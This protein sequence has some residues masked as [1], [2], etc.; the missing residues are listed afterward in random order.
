L[1]APLDATPIALRVPATIKGLIRNFGESHTASSSVL[2]LFRRKKEKPVHVKL[3]H[4]HLAFQNA[5]AVYVEAV[6]VRGAEH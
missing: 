3:V 4:I 1:H 5:F 6:S 2:Q